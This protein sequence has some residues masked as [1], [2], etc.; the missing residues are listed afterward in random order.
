MRGL[1]VA[2]PNRGG[3]A[4]ALT[5]AAWPSRTARHFSIGDARAGS[6]PSLPPSISL[7][8]RVTP[9]IPALAKVGEASS[10]SDEAAS[11][12]DR[13]PPLPPIGQRPEATL[14]TDAP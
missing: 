7:H 6:T 3:I 9:S 1:S 4:T 14:L 10:S 12:D 11:V 13:V 5:P 8:T 2:S